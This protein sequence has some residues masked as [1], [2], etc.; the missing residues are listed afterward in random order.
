M[1]LIYGGDSMSFVCIQS[2][3]NSMLSSAA[4]ATEDFKLIEKRCE[5]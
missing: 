5:R 1:S 2:L 3:K 4:A